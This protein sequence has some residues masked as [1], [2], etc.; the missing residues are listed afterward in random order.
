MP[1][2]ALPADYELSLSID[3][4]QYDADDSSNGHV[5]RSDEH[6]CSVGVYDNIGSISVRVTDDRVDGFASYEELERIDYDRDRRDGVLLEGIDAAR[7]WMGETDPAAWAHPEVC[8][9]V[10]DAPVGYTLET[11][12]HENR[13]AI[14]YYRRE[15]A[16]D[17]VDID[18]RGSDGPEGLSHANAPYLYV[19]EWRGSGNA[20]VAL[21][22]WTEAHGPGSKHPDITPVVET[23]SECGLE[24]AVTMARRWAREYADKEI[25]TDASGQAALERWSA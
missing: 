16:D 6:E 15:G 25:D 12:Y 9:A 22:P 4:W 17:G 10:F 5:W 7:G 8:E 21:A 18:V 23:P 14:V 13:E 3:G 1:K 11:Y 24:V 19:H 20:T 2:P